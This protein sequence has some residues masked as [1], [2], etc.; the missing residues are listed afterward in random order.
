[1]FNEDVRR[2][3]KETT[4]EHVACVCFGKSPE[5]VHRKIILVSFNPST[6]SRRTGA[7]G[8]ADPD[9]TA[10]FAPTSSSCNRSTFVSIRRGFVRRKERSK[11]RQVVQNGYAHHH[12]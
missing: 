1:M 5:P 3:T 11:W 7:T 8:E 12:R 9:A 4:S 10:G 2:R 6:V